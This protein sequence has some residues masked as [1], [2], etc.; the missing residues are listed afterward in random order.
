M[1]IDAGFVLEPVPTAS[2]GDYTFI[3]NNENGIQDGGD[4]PLSGVTVNLYDASD[5]STPIATDV[6]DGSGLYLFTNLDPDLDYVVEFVT[7]AGYDPTT[8]T[9]N[10]SDGVADDSDAA[11]NGFTNVIDLNPGETDLTIDA[12]FVLEPVPTASLGDYT[13]IDNNENGIQDGGDQPLSGV[14]VNLYDASDLSTPI[15]TDVTDGSGLYL[16]TN[17]DPDL[18]YVVEF[19]TPAGYDPTTQTGNASDG[20]ADDS[21]A[22]ANGFTNVIDLNPGETDLT[23]D[24]GFVLEPVPTASL[25]DYTFIDNNENG[26]Q[27]GGDQPLSGVTVNLYDASDLSTPI[28][29]DVTDGSGLYLFTNLDPDLDYV[30]EFVTPAGYDPT[31]QTGNASDGVADDSDAAANGFTNVIDLNPG[32][33]DLD[34]RRRFRIGTRTDGKFG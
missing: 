15:A 19:V 33:T 25:G 9:G 13:F 28:A 14:T 6:T 21:D 23:I 26:I 1:T 4:Q 16:F 8:Q 32:E 30:V 11:A 12:G 27:D 22:A 10:A 17:L 34:D 24:A 20:V 3:D 29:T 2:L 18:D 5:L 7:P 31:T